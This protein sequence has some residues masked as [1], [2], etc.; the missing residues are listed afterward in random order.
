M[1]TLVWIATVGIVASSY[2][3]EPTGAFDGREGEEPKTW[4]EDLRFMI[5]T[6]RAE[7]ALRDTFE[8]LGKLARRGS[9]R[10][11][12]KEYWYSTFS[13]AGGLIGFRV[14]EDRSGPGLHPNILLGV[15]PASMKEPPPFPFPLLG[16]VGDVP[17]LAR[18]PEV[19]PAPPVDTEQDTYFGQK[20]TVYVYGAGHWITRYF[21][22]NDRILAIAFALE[23]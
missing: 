13:I 23:P 15:H 14:S 7:P 22:K 6:S 3:A 10:K 17:L 4:Q 11:V 2:G 5:E 12:T 9:R 16:K 8:H 19:R 20:C 1:R 18:K 21:V